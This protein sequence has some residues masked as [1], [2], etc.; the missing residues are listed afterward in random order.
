MKLIASSKQALEHQLRLGKHKQFS[1]FSRA[2]ERSSRCYRDAESVKVQTPL[3][4]SPFRHL[5]ALAISNLH[6]AQLIDFNYR[7]G[8][9]VNAGL[10]RFECVTRLLD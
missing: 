2:G 8:E 4:H 3:I 7:L 1:C 9:V 10:L 6:V 5:V